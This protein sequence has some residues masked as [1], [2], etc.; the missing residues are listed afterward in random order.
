MRMMTKVAL[1]AGVAYAAKRAY[2][3]YM[4]SGRQY[5]PGGAPI[6]YD[7]PT[8]TDPAA[9]YTEPGYQDKSFGQA[10][11]QDQELADRLV[12]ESH[13]DMSEAD[14]RF[15]EMSAGSPTLE[16]QERGSAE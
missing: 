12:Q 7:T 3:T 14:A 11:A 1:L 8:G 4:A 9:K 15:R 6:G 13:G 16:R 2:E 5:A 10:V